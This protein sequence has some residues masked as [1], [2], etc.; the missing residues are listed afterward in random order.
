MGKLQCGRCWV[1]LRR[2]VICSL[3]K[4]VSFCSTRLCFALVRTVF[5]WWWCV[6]Q[7]VVLYLLISV[8]FI[9]LGTRVTASAVRSSDIE[10]QHNTHGSE[11]QEGTWPDPLLEPNSQDMCQLEEWAY[12]EKERAYFACVQAN[13]TFDRTW[14]ADIDSFVASDPEVTPNAAQPASPGLSSA[15]DLKKDGGRPMIYHPLDTP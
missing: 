10:N 13:P 14:P 2:C 6:Q 15:R 3:V 12:L 7:F 9:N 1:R 5:G 11:E 8:P 4:M